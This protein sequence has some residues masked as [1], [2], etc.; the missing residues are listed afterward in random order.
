M[1][2]IFDQLSQE[3]WKLDGAFKALH[4][5]NYV[6]VALVNDIVMNEIKKKKT[7]N[8][9]IGPWLWRGDFL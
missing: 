8:F 5:F 2:N 4:S 1:S 7:G 9:F 3:W 6:R